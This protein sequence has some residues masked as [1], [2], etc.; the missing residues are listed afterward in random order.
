[1]VHENLAHETGRKRVEVAAIAPVHRRGTH[2]AQ[3]RLMYQCGR[4]KTVTG[5]LAAH[6]PSRALMQFC[7]DQGSQSLEGGLI[8]TAPGSEPPGDIVSWGRL[9]GISPVIPQG[10]WA[11]S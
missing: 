8:P 5:A 11:G 4:L 9:H 1:M 2:Q 7:V 6:E 3:I 10:E